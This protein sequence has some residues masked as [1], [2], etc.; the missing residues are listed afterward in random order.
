MKVIACAFPPDWAV[1]ETLA[2]PV[3]LDQ[4]PPKGL[5]G[6][7][8]FRLNGLI[9]GLLLERLLGKDDP[10]LLLNPERMVAPELL[11]VPLGNHE[12]LNLER[13]E[14]WLNKTT[15]QLFAAGARSFALAVQDLYRP[16]F[17]SREF[18]GSLLRSL[19]RCQFE[20][21]KFYTDLDLAEKLVQEF[22]RW[23]Y[24]YQS[25]TP[26]EFSVRDIPEV[27]GAKDQ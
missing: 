27:F 17:P 12:A 11:L 22:S 23:M 16:E 1:R 21:V 10:W 13:V 18:A 20:L 4:V 14:R 24:H 5:A 7:I 15:D 8:D 25:E 19:L 3:F 26:V 6:R 9:S 2:L